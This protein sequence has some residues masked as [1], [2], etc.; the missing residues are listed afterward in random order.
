MRQ[1][2]YR[3]NG[4]EFAGSLGDLGTLLPLALAR[5]HLFTA[6]GWVLPVVISLSWL[7]VAIVAAKLPIRHKSGGRQF[8]SYLA[9]TALAIGAASIGAIATVRKW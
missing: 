4:L 9:G 8:A 7:S 1:P 5:S 6:S 2:R 3:F